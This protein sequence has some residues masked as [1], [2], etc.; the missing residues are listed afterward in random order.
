MSAKSLMLDLAVVHT[1]QSHPGFS[2]Q[3]REEIRVIVSRCADEDLTHE[4]ASQLC[5]SKFHTKL[6]IDHLRMIRDVDKDPLPPHHCE[7]EEG[8]RRKTH[9]WTSA[10]DTQ[11]LAGIYRFG[12]ASWSTVAQ[13]DGCSRTRSQCSQRWVRGLDARISRGPWTSSEDALLLRLVA[14]YDAK[15]WILVSREMGN[16]S[17]VQCRYRYRYL[18]IQDAT[19][20]RDVIDS[21][22]EEEMESTVVMAELESTPPKEFESPRSDDLFAFEQIGLDLGTQSMSEI[23]WMLHP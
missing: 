8:S 22:K 6:P 21:G 17:D 11:L 23:F 14:K 9:P 10:E 18:Q 3:E 4:Q 16:R 5:L 15:S 12:L 13:F 7:S 2:E 19:L 20:V 1:L